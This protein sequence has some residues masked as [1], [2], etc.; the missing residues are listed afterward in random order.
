ML[1]RWDDYLDEYDDKKIIKFRGLFYLNKWHYFKTNLNNLDETELELAKRL[2]KGLKELS[3]EE[4]ELLAEKFDRPLVT[5]NGINTRLKDDIIAEK[6]H[7]KVRDY[8]IK[9]R[10]IVVKLENIIYQ[11]QLN[12]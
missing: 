2:F 8:R 12:G 9:K 3:S 7:C 11:N 10:K 1:N 4:R 6:H 5:V